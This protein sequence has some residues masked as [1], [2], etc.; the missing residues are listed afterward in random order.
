MDIN[1]F[2]SSLR[3]RLGAVIK[4]LNIDHEQLDQLGAAMHKIA[5]LMT[6]LNIFATTYV[7]KNDQ[8]KIE[9]YKKT[10]PELFSEYFYLNRVLQLE[11]TRS[12]VGPKKFKRHCRKELKR[13]EAFFF[14]NRSFYVYYVSGQTYSDSLYFVRQNSLE[15]MWSVDEESSISHDDIITKFIGLQKFMT[16]LGQVGTRKKETPLSW[17]GA[18]VDLI[19]LIYSLHCSRVFDNGAIDIKSI[20]IF[21]ERSFQINLGNYYRV[22]QDIKRRKTDRSKFLT[23]LIGNLENK[24]LLQED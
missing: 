22:F 12:I 2:S 4:D 6:E 11:V 23:S 7:F 1:T 9:F 13:A 10:K 20:I 5:G 17:T 19:E 21:F 16:Y 14:S 8:E 3:S 24:I 18:K 15:K